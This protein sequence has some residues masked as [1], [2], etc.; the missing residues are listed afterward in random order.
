MG[1]IL[2]LDEV[3]SSV[4]GPTN[5]LIIRVIRKEF[6]NYTVVAV[7]HRMETVIDFDRIVVI[8]KVKL[9]DCGNPKIYLKRE[10]AREHKAG[11]T[12]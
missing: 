3:S 10:T 9:K 12:T 11:T 6:W 8:E 4:D 2:L 5:A 7:A 1:G